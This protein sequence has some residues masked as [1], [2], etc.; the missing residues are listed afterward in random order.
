MRILCIAKCSE[1]VGSGHFARQLAICESAL[2]HGL[3][4]VIATL[5][6]PGWFEPDGDL[7]ILSGSSI[8]EILRSF[9][10][11]QFDFA[12]IDSPDEPE[13]LLR[14]ARSAASHVCVIDDYCRLEHSLYDVVVVPGANGQSLLSPD[15]FQCILGGPSFVP[16]R[17]PVRS[18]RWSPDPLRSKLLISSGGVLKLEFLEPI[19]STVGF[20]EGYELVVAAGGLGDL[21]SELEVLLDKFGVRMINP[22][23][24]LLELQSARLV[25]TAVGVGFWEAL[26]MGV[27]AVGILSKPEDGV[28]FSVRDESSTSAVIDLGDR[29]FGTRL[30]ETIGQFSLIDQSWVDDDRRC[31]TVVDGLGADRIVETLVK[32]ASG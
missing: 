25:V 27:P 14:L 18:M 4:P 15:S 30:R 1:E 21:S 23:R 13:K 3:D 24:Y 11:G 16:V 6:V 2:R 29:E 31:R 9:K 10:A 12:V 17:N 28:V 20:L 32:V 7:E 22:T 8:Y 26:S 19:L 5:R